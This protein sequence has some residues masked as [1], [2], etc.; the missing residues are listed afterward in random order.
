MR[1]TLPL[2]LFVV[3]LS[4][5]PAALASASW[6]T[7]PEWARDDRDRAR[8]SDGG[9]E[10]SLSK[11]KAPRKKEREISPF[12]PNT[13]NIA[14]DVGQV[15]LMG[16][17]ASNYSNAIGFRAHYTYGVSEMF[18]VDSSFGYSNHSSGRFSLMSGQAGL[19][20]NLTFFDKIVPFAVA[21]L[22]FFRPSFDIP[23]ENGVENIAPVA[24]GLH[25][26]PGVHLEVTSRLFFGISLQ[27]QT[28]FNSRHTLSNNR[29]VEIGG[30]YTSFFLHAG[31]TL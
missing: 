1:F 23:T 8:I 18:G 19:R 15:F 2:L 16:D 30:T 26:S 17:M 13:H 21:G 20:V 11:G 10:I 14:I 25:I 22:G 6:K 12:A 7:E 31:F 27:L 24:F 28:L 9:E 3:S 29:P 5:L 4:S